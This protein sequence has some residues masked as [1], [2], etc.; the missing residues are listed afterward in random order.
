MLAFD[1]AQR[2]IRLHDVIRQ[3]LFRNLGDRLTVL[4]ADFLD[5]HRPANTRWADLPPAEPYLWDH[6]A[7]HLRAANR[8]AELVAA[9]LDV[10]YLAAKTLSW[11]ALATERDLV[12]AEQTAPDPQ[13]LGLLRRSFVQSSHVFN[14]CETRADLEATLRSRL[15]HLSTSRA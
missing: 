6:L 10:R 3:H 2:F 13:A 4:Q 5:A 7:Y 14:R 9:V 1:P 11:N 15:Q 12:A 8:N